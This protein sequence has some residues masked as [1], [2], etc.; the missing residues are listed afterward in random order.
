METS[1]GSRIVK[2]LGGA[3]LGIGVAAL[4]YFAM[5]WSSF[6]NI[7]GYLVNGLAPTHTDQV[8]VNDKTIDDRTLARI[9][10]RAKEVTA[11][12]TPVATHAAASSSS[13]TMRRRADT[14]AA[15]RAQVEQNASL[16]SAAPMQDEQEV[17]KPVGK[18][19]PDSGP[20]F[21]ILAV[22]SFAA[23]VLWLR[24]DRRLTV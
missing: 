3:A 8:R 7:Q 9:T 10:E 17:M 24:P 22:I 16:K 2:Q 18:S 6:S 21:L 1:T 11:Q 19:L 13:N 15:L 12:I 5:S 23:A 4:I 20:G 14:R